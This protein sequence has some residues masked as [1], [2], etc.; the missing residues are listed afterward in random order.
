MKSIIQKFKKSVIK[1]FKDESEFE[2]FLKEETSAF[3]GKSP[4]DWLLHS[5]RKDRLSFSIQTV[6]E[7]KTKVATFE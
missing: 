4:E 6:I 5:R 1:H 2:S 7:L 3:G